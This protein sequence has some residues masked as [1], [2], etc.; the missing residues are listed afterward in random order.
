MLIKRW[1]I[2]FTQITNEGAGNT[3]KIIVG[4]EGSQA[5]KLWMQFYES[6]IKGYEINMEKEIKRQIL[7]IV[8]F[9]ERY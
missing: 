6:V 8:W 5:D 9:C 7:N 4:E 3:S 1:A 2:V